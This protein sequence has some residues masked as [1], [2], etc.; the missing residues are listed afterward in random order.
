MIIFYF[1]GHGEIAGGEEGICPYDYN[2]QD[3]RGLIRNEEIQ[4]IMG[5]SPARHKICF[6]EA[7]KTEVQKQSILDPTYLKSFNQARRRISDGLVFITSTEAG[8]P[9]FGDPQSIG[10]YFTH[11]LLEGLEGKANL[12]NDAYIRVDELFRYVEREVSSYTNGAQVPQINDLGGYDGNLPLIILPEKLPINPPDVE[13]YPPGFEYL[14]DQM[15][16]I[17]GG[18]FQMGDTYHEGAGDE[19]PVHGVSVSSFYLSR[20]E[21]TNAQF[22]VFLNEKGNQEEGGT[23][24][25]DI[26][27]SS[28]K[29]EKVG[30]RYRSKNGFST[31]P[32]VKVS[33]YG[34]RAYCQW[35][36]DKTGRPF[37]LPSEAEWEYAA[38]EK[39]RKVRFGNGKDIADPA[40]INFDGSESYKKAYSVAGQYRGGTVPVNTLTSNGLGL[41]H[42]SV[43]V[44]EWCEDAWHDSYAGAPSNGRA[45]VSGGDPSRRV[46]RGGSWDNFPYSCRVAYRLRFGAS[47]RSGITGFRL[48]W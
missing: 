18:T 17:A 33:W 43:N 21:V 27:S 47:F 5:E 38:R 32:V 10:G 15:V 16:S 41:Y 30:G 45:W 44:W 4:E 37:R 28:C 23:T 39:G 14:R 48:A 25:L 46:V 34:A 3:V 36:A 35:L 13:D 26:E 42:M 29:I 22:C 20:Y 8:Q 40:E 19:K 11:Y 7:C 12:D 1:S 6:I 31:H 2:P 9:S 24:W